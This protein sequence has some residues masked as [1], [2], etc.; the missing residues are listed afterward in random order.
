[1]FCG[2]VAKPPPHKTP[3]S[4]PPV[5]ARWN[6]ISLHGQMWNYPSSKRQVESSGNTG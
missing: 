4:F 2:A 5:H 3:F 1:M 6:A